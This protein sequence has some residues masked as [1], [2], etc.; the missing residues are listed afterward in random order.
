MALTLDL[1]QKYMVW[2]FK[3]FTPIWFKVKGNEKQIIEIK[4]VLKNGVIL[5]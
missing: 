5:K 3:I 1:L 4:N 2:F